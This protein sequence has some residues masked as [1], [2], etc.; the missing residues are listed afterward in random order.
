[1]KEPD[2]LTSDCDIWQLVSA[3]F[4]HYKH[5]TMSTERELYYGND[6]WSPIGASGVPAFNSP[7]CHTHWTAFSTAVYYHCR[8]QRA[9]RNDPGS[10]LRRQS[11]VSSRRHPE[12]MQNNQRILHE[13]H[14]NAFIEISAILCPLIAQLVERRTV[15]CIVDILRSLVRIRLD[16]VI[17]LRQ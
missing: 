4:V 7:L 6:W 17:L 9:R 11:F 15:E 3:I 10:R 5:R 14:L 1:M 16:G 8:I 13:W 2:L 12:D